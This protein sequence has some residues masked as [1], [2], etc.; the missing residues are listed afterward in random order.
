MACVH[1]VPPSRCMRAAL[2][3]HTSRRTRAAAV[4]QG[5]GCWCGHVG[6]GH[7]S[8]GVGAWVW[9]CV[10]RVGGQVC[11]AHVWTRRVLA[12]VGLCTPGGTGLPAKRR[13]SEKKKKP[14]LLAGG[15]GRRGCV[16]AW[17][18]ACM[19]IVPPSHFVCA[20][21]DMR[22]QVC[23]GTQMSAPMR[24]RVTSLSCCVCVGGQ[25]C[26]LAVTLHAV[27]AGD[28][29]EGVSLASRVESHNSVVWLRT[30]VSSGNWPTFDTK[31]QKILWASL[32]G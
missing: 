5:R 16:G 21:L 15:I 14:H 29:R 26:C 2:P 8:V 6:S 32:G 31:K 1:V 25:M 22:G 12:H 23:W 19:P 9:V 3:C 27:Y 13:V 20:A 10:R 7:G 17:V 11:R 30:G 28:E 24:T 18:R 4:L